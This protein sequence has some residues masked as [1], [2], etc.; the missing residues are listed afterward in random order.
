MHSVYPLL[1]LRNLL[2]KIFEDF[3]SKIFLTIF[4]SGF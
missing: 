1:L 3:K 4:K 2:L